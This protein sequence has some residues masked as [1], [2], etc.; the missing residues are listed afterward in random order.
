MT[1]PERSH[2]H[3]SSGFISAT[4]LLGRALRSPAKDSQQDARQYDDNREFLVIPY[5]ARC[6]GSNPVPS[7]LQP[8]APARAIGPPQTLSIRTCAQPHAN[9]HRQLKQRPRAS[10]NLKLM[11]AFTSPGRKEDVTAPITSH[12]IAQS[13]GVATATP[14]ASPRPSPRRPHGVPTGVP[15]G[16]PRAARSCRCMAARTEP[17]P[18]CALAVGQRGHASPWVAVGH[19]APDLFERFFNLCVIRYKIKSV[20]PQRALYVTPTNDSM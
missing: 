3:Y 15:T 13:I 14:R 18:R 8:C 20:A 19:S 2:A 16:V 4:G 1:R 5:S 12:A 17:G 11:T 6:V 10:S 9:E 7:G